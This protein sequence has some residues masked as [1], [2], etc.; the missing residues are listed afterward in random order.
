MRTDSESICSIAYGTLCVLV[1]AA[2]G[3]IW[4][5][6]HHAI[7]LHGM[8]MRD[9]DLLKVPAFFIALLGFALL[10]RWKPALL[11]FVTITAGLGAVL[12]AGS[13]WQSIAQTPWVLLNIP[14]GAVLLV[15]LL[16]A[17]HYWRT[18]RTS[19]SNGY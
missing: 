15:P 2:I 10:A 5:S 18:S 7:A 19:P 4:F 1:A 17:I 14:F 11:L 13:L 9:L 16:L 12:I 3:L 8:N 6:N